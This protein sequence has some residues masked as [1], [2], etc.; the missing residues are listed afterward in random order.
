[1]RVVYTC[2]YIKC[3]DEMDALTLKGMI[4]EL[5]ARWVSYRKVESSNGLG[6]VCCFFSLDN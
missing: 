2:K 1:M 6:D 3:T 4:G 5:I